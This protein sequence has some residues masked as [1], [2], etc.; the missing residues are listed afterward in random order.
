MSCGATRPA[1][2]GSDVVETLMRIV[3]LLSLAGIAACSR[4]PPKP[5][6][7]TTIAAARAKANIDRY[8]AAKAAAVATRTA[9]ASGH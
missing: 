2:R 7:T 5:I 9:H 3:I 6:D 8:A 1:S 4:P